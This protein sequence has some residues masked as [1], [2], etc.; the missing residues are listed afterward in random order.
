MLRSE[1]DR[2]RVE[3]HGKDNRLPT[4]EGAAEPTPSKPIPVPAA[5]PAPEAREA[6]APQKAMPSADTTKT[7]GD[8]KP[9]F[10]NRLF[11]G[12]KDSDPD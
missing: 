7:S 4:L 5:T 3:L 11:G 10:W 9:G 1:I 6:A 2:L 12:K 8:D